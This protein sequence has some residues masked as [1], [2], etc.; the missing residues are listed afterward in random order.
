ME[1]DFKIR[2][3]PESKETC[4]IIL[5]KK[6]CDQGPQNPENIKIT[7]ELRRMVHLKQEL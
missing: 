3:Q 4:A 2:F 1:Q 7:Q 5:R 6:A